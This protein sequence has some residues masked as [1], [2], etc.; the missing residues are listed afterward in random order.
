MGGTVS[1][2]GY[3]KYQGMQASELRNVQVKIHSGEECSQMYNGITTVYNSTVMLCAGGGDKDACQGDS[4]GPLVAKD[5][6]GAFKLVEIVSWG[7]GCATPN[8]PGAYAKISHYHELI[9]QKIDETEIRIVS[10]NIRTYNKTVI[11]VL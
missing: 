7:I 11:F 6:R 8:V 2:F 5:K 9:R 1:G 10:L 3:L 4:G